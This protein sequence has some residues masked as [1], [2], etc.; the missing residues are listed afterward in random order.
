MTYFLIIKKKK[1]IIITLFIGQCVYRSNI[2]RIAFDI[3]DHYF[4]QDKHS[5]WFKSYLHYRRQCVCG[6]VF[7]AVSQ[8]SW[9]WQKVQAVAVLYFH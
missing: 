5:L 9:S 7:R 1:I 3:V 6:S 8:A 2:Y 4:L